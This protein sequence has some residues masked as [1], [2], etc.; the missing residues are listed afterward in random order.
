MQ[1]V[2]AWGLRLR[3]RVLVKTG[4]VKRLWGMRLVAH[5][6][7]SKSA[8]GRC[9]GAFVNSDSTHARAQV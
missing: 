1:R 2:G 4:R 9:S 7:G 8:G 6:H 3:G 5:A